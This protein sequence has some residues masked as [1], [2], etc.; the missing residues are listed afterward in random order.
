MPVE[1][2]TCPSKFCRLK[3]GLPPSAGGMF[4]NRTGGHQGTAFRQKAKG[5]RRPAGKMS[6]IDELADAL[7]EHD[8]EAGDSGG[9][10]RA[11]AAR[12]GISYA[13]ANSLVQRMR[14]RINEAQ[15]AAGFGDWA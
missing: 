3:R 9:D 7:A 2:E 1:I 15:R 12:I 6:K 11:C 14:R 13:Q 8:A 5:G 10:V 4:A